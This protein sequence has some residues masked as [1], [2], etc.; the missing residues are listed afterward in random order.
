[1]PFGDVM[2]K[3][4]RDNFNLKSRVYDGFL[5][6]F[7]DKGVQINHTLLFE[8]TQKLQ[9]KYFRGRCVRFPFCVLDPCFLV[10]SQVNAPTQ[11]RWFSLSRMANQT[12]KDS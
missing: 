6:A 7:R 9:L 10:L 4:I 1:M 3:L 12:F 2:K 11:E 8:I 5:L